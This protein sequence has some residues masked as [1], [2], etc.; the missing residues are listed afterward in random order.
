M[1]SYKVIIIDN[2]PICPGE[3]EIECGSYNRAMKI[4]MEN[5]EIDPNSIEIEVWVHDQFGNENL[6]ADTSDLV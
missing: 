5:F 4:A 3:C 6:V 1:N 2:D